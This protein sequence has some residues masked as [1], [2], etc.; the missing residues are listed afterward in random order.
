MH[1]FLKAHIM[2]ALH[3]GADCFAIR[4]SLICAVI[5]SISLSLGSCGGGGG[6]GDSGSGS[7]T[8]W[9]TIQSSAIAHDENGIAMANLQGEAFV[10]DETYIAHRC[11]GL[12]C[13]FGWYDNS[14]PGVD[15]TWTNLTTGEHGIAT[16][17]Y[18]TA[19]SWD[20]LWYAEVPILF[21]SNE[22]QVTAADPAGNSATQALTIEYIPPPPP[23]LKA[24]TGDGQITLLWSAIPGITAYRIYMSTTPLAA[25][26]QGDYMDT[27]GPP[28]V[29]SGLA[30]GTTYYYAITSLH[31]D[32]ESQ[33]TEEVAATAGAPSRPMNLVATPSASDI[34]LSWDTVG[35]A[36]YYTL[37]WSNESGVNIGNGTAIP[38]ATS[39]FLHT[40]LEGI[41]YFYVVTASNGHGESLESLEAMATP[42]IAPPPPDGLQVEQRRGITEYLETVDLW[43]E[44][45]PGVQ[46]YDVYRCRTGATSGE[47]GCEPSPSPFACIAPWERLTSIITDTSFVDRDIIYGAA[48]WYYITAWNGYDTSQ[49]SEWAG[50]CIERQLPVN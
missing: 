10:A 34:V 31:L 50:L 30:N 49:H 38:G 36:D 32:R 35:S 17:R 2:P 14:Y 9:I 13:I 43:W 21:G 3:T 39:P 16:S 20:H 18:G 46:S 47:A 19:T 22:I 42:P 7:N 8:G 24:D 5:V 15:V 29:H 40:G 26:T 28:H 25:Y 12:A 41:P 45:V 37:Y 27:S 11:V 1:S 33:P 23:D 4:I 48:Y 6:G 44:P